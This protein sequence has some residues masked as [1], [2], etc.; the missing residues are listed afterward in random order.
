MGA[1]LL[2][3]FE[4]SRYEPTL[5]AAVRLIRRALAVYPDSAQAKTLFA[6]ALYLS[7]KS[8]EAR[9]VVETVT[10]ASADYAPAWNLRGLLA[11]RDR[12][13]HDAFTFF[14]KATLAM[15]TYVP[16]LINW[17]STAARVG[18]LDTA[19]AKLTLALS[20][21][22]EKD[23]LLRLSAAYRA[24]AAATVDWATRADLLRR[25]DEAASRAAAMR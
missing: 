22:E 5:K 17:A 18:D 16:A 8:R 9:A 23:A 2:A 15:P 11:A 13:F 4:G 14:G 12:A 21:G 1:L 7:D 20:M 10:T 6:Y 25:A 3:E 19:I 24:K